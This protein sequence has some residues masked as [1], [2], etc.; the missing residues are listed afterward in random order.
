MCAGIRSRAVCACGCAHTA[1]AR[2]H[3]TGAVAALLVYTRNALS[4]TDR[5]CPNCT[6]R[7]ETGGGKV[8]SQQRRKQTQAT[9]LRARTSATLARTLRRGPL[10]YASSTLRAAKSFCAS[11]GIFGAWRASERTRAL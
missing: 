11:D 1:N 8:P 3:L 5:D 2:I 4:F 6:T 7:S 9:P 10:L